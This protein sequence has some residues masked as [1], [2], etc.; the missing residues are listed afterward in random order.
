MMKIDDAIERLAFIKYLYN[1]GLEQSE[2]AKPYCWTSVLIFHDAIELFLELASE[3]VGVQKR[4]EE[5]RFMEYWGLINPILKQKGKSELTQKISMEKLNKVRV[6]FKHHGTQP[7]T[8]AIGDSRTSATNFSE[9]NT[10]IVFDVRFPDTSFIDLVHCE[11]AKKS[12]MDAQKMLDANKMKDALEN[13]GI[14]F[15]QLVDDYENRKK[16]QFGRS[17]FFFGSST[18][19]PDVPDFL[20]DMRDYFSEIN[21]SIEALQDAVKML[22]FGFDYRRYVRFRLLTPIILR[23]PGG[24]YQIQWISHGLSKTPKPDDAQFCIDFVIESAIV[25]QEFD[26]EIERAK[27]PTLLDLK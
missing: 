4:L 2:R 19:G 7:S 8:S 13:A 24:K 26:F 23:I 6:A 21:K 14:A 25:L 12:L 17:P 10:P 9:E 22:S 15:V 1:A 27:H 3:Y 18:Y 20:D 16:D 11:Q 5:L